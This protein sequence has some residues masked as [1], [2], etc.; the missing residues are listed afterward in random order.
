MD[1]EQGIYDASKRRRFLDQIH[2]SGNHLLQLINDILDLS[3]VEAGQMEL[4]LQPVLVVDSVREVIATVDPLA[5]AKKILIET[6]LAPGLELTADPAKL[7]Q[8]LLNLMSNAI[9]F[10]PEHGRITVR[11]DRADEWVEIAVVDTGMGIA[12]AHLHLL[13]GEFQQIPAGPGRKPEGTGLGLALTK[14]F[15]ALHGGD[16][17]VVS[18][19]GEGST[20]TIRLPVGAKAVVV[21][22]PKKFEPATPVD[23][24]RPLVLVVDDNPQAAEIMTRHLE[25]GGFRIEI[26]HTGSDALRMAR[27]LKPAAV[28][29][30]ILLPEIDGWEVL[31][32][33]KD[34]EATRDIPVVVVSVVDNPTLGRALGA[35]D[36]FVKPVDGKALLSRFAQYTFTPRAGQQE[37]TVLVVDDEAA[38]LDLIEALLKPAG[39]NVLRASGGQEGIEIARSRLPNLILLDLMM[40]GVSGF[41]VVEQLRS[42]DQTRA[43]PI[44]ILT[45]KTLTEDDKQS[46]S[47]NV[48]EIF[49]RNS[50]AGTELV[51]WLRGIVLKTTSKT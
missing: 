22:P 42:Q 41:E 1:D 39:F 44:M 37:V 17:T 24:S 5:R 45:A 26:A 16:V 28:T 10:T 15:A 14:R 6:E 19:V 29:L 49:Q 38:N 32:R 35:V 43:I 34:D 48:A 25:R 30:D 23:P 2:Q 31:S 3:K 40:P 11:A 12:E 46:L 9:K 13:F 4:E 21:A 18:H 20:F 51:E 33:L 47:G 7:K 8:M 50:V 36:Y 27:E